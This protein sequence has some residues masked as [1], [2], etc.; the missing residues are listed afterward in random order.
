MAPITCC[1][2]L[3]V[4]LA[5]AAA[6]AAAAGLSRVGRQHERPEI[7]HRRYLSVRAV[8]VCR[9]SDGPHQ[10]VPNNDDLRYNVLALSG[11]VA[12]VLSP[13]GA[14]NAAVEFLPE[15]F[16]YFF[17]ESSFSEQVIFF[18]FF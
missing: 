1:A 11:P 6:V 16:N 9:L 17:A 12:A 3:V 8:L 18:F 2:F 14:K 13:R 15:Q 4:C 7:S 5:A 10:V